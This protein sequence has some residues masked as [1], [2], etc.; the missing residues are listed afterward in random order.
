MSLCPDDRSFCGG[1]RGALELELGVADRDEDGYF[2]VTG[3]S[4]GHAVQVRLSE[5]PFTKQ[6]APFED[7]AY[8]SSHQLLSTRSAPDSLSR[9]HSGSRARSMNSL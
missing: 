8:V 9:E 3:A 1:R 7:S 2:F 6:S 4:A 5:D